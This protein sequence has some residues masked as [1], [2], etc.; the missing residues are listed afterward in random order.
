[1]GSGGDGGGGGGGSGGGGRDSGGSSCHLGKFE[2]DALKY[3]IILSFIANPA[4]RI[5]TCTN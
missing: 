1:M 3:F 2:S 4:K 5:E